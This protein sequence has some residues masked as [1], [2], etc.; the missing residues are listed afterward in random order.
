M[1][2]R[3]LFVTFASAAAL[4]FWPALIAAWKQRR[5]HQRWERKLAHAQA[6]FRA[7]LRAK[8]LDPDRMTEDQAMDYVDR[9]IDEYRAEQR[10]KA[11]VG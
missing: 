7:R 6:R 9:L 5:E 4:C 8:G 2:R 11:H 3:A 10:A 1:T